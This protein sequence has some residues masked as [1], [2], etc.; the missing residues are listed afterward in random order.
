MG[1]GG[2]V[3]FYEKFTVSIEDSARKNVC[4]RWLDEHVAV[5]FAITHDE[6][7]ISDNKNTPYA[8]YAKIKVQSKF[9]ETQGLTK[10]I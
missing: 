3:K 9:K 5:P 6:C 2:E 7:S 8:L 1:K 10:N 4:T